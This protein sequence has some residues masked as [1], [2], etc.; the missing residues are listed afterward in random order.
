MIEKEEIKEEVRYLTNK[1]KIKPLVDEVGIEHILKYLME[2][3]DSLDI[4]SDEDMW[5]FRVADALED[6]YDGYINRLSM[7]HN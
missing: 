5:K 7:E 2:Q 1:S 3:I 6:A 4:E